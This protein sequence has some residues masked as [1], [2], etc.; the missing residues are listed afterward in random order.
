MAT[1]QY[2]GAATT[3][4]DNDVPICLACSDVRELEQRCELKVLPATKLLTQ[5]ISSCNYAATEVYF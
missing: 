1:C 3:L 4:Y 2:C 5:K